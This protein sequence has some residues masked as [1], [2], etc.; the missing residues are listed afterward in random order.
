MKKTVKTAVIAILFTGSVLVHG[1]EKLMIDVGA[2]VVSS[3]VWRGLYQAGVSVQPSLSLSTSGL[4]LGAWGSTDFSTYFK[5]LDFYLSYE[6]KG[7]SAG[8]TNYWWSGEGASFFEDRGS[9]LFEVNLG[10]TFSEKFPLSLGVNTMLSGDDDKNNNDK[11]R[12]STYISADFPFSVKKIDCEVGIGIS[13]S[14]G[15]YS[16]TF[17]VATITA[18]ASKNLSL[19]SD[20]AIP[21]FVKLICSPAQDNAFLVFGL[22][23]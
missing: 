8:I 12:Y 22:T 16:D 17:D 18:K 1:Q 19:S 21:V 15:L 14:K 5:E 11:Q 23:F 10:Y 9:H 20:Y 2:D 4:T 13:P 6:M 7:F 3:Y